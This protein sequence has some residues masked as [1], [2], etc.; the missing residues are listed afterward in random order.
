MPSILF[1]CTANI[2]RSPMAAALFRRH[3]ERT[4]QIQKFE[5]A[6]A[7]TWATDGLPAARRVRT[8]MREFGIDIESHQSQQISR[9]LIDAS[10]VIVVMTDDHREVLQTEFP[11]AAHRIHRL[12]DLAGESFD[13]PDPINGTLDDVRIVARELDELIHQSFP[14][15]VAA[16]GMRA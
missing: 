10:D 8:A 4:N 6:S 13:V 2:C 11:D 15:I 9:S 1:V 7:G 5:I 3:A 14:S 12:S 16:A